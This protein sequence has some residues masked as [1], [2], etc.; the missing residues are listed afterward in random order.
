MSFDA[1]VRNPWR[2]LGSARFAARFQTI[3]RFTSAPETLSL[4][5]QPLSDLRNLS[6]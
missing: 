3:L 5:E 6:H 2:V 1:F 4:D